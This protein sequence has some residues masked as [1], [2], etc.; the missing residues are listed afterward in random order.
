MVKTYK[1]FRFREPKVHTFK[2]GKAKVTYCHAYADALGKY[3]SVEVQRGTKRYAYIT[4]RVTKP[5]LIK[6]FKNT[7][8]SRRK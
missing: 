6:Q 7:S 4:R 1:I 3:T 2:V 5:E 8:W